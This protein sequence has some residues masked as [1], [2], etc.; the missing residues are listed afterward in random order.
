MVSSPSGDISLASGS[1]PP[2]RSE[3]PSQPPPRCRS[4]TPSQPPPKSRSGTPSQRPPSTCSTTPSQ[5][6]AKIRRRG[7][8]CDDGAFFMAWLDER[9]TER[10][11]KRAER[12]P[13]FD[14]D[15]VFGQQVATFMRHFTIA[16]RS[17]APIQIFQ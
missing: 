7:N 17:S 11:E 13:G 12:R 6:P 10:E 5:P 9:R 16:Q 1:E 15:Q 3:T 4:E 8:D 14:E 2:S